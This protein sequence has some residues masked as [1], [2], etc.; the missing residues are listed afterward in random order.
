[1]TLQINALSK[2]P[3]PD[4]SPFVSFAKGTKE[5]EALVLEIE[6]LRKADPRIFPLLVAGCY[7]F[8]RLKEGK[9]LV[10]HHLG[11]CLGYYT[12]AN[13]INVNHAIQGVLDAREKWS[14]VPWPI[15]FNIFRRTARLMET[16][17][18]IPLVAAVM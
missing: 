3:K 14:Q 6:K 5:R 9:C 16:K 8:N 12:M 4:N 7:T 1:M 15:R 10:P 17:Y 18:L 13:E 2:I 11:A